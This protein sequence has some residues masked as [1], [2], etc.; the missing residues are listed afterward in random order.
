MVR[1]QFIAAGCG[2][3]LVSGIAAWAVDAFAAPQAQPAPTSKVPSPCFRVADVAGI[4]VSPPLGP[5]Q[6]DGVYLRLFN[7]DVYQLALG[8]ICPQLRG[9][10]RIGIQS[11]SGGLLLCKAEDAVIVARDA[12][13][14]LHGECWGDTL[15]KLTP[16][17]LAAIP[18]KERP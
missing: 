2:L 16:A 8:T 13:S 15:K 18:E 7:H 17:E 1:A 4:S 9:S 14:G 3:A 6:E 12:T 11:R 10:V 5:K